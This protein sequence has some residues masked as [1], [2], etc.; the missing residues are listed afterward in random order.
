[1]SDVA[2]DVREDV[3]R[4]R[5]E[6]GETMQTL[7]EKSHTKRRAGWAAA[8]TGLL[9]GVAA[10]GAMRWRKAR[11][12]PRGRAERAWRGMKRQVRRTAARIR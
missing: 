12:T 9:A 4:T 5:T 7:A 2:E 11:Q 8:A 3:A 6:L 10:V 1:M